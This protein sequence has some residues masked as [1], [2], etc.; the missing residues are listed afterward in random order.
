MGDPVLPYL[1]HIDDAALVQEHLWVRARRA[2]DVATATVNL[3]RTA[4]AAAACGGGA[5]QTGAGTG[6]T[7][8]RSQG[9]ADPATM[10]H[11]AGVAGTAVRSQG[12]ADPAAVL[13]APLLSRDQ[14]QWMLEALTREPEP[15]SEGEGRAVGLHCRVA[16]CRSCQRYS[17]AV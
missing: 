10:A 5:T 11:G 7:A 17:A 16:P 6:A 4:A 8:V 15:P 12:F 2:G 1:S 13:S 14:L 9:G 3:S